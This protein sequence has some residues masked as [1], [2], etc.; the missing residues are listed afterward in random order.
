MNRLAAVLSIGLVLAAPLAAHAQDMGGIDPTDDELQL[1]RFES[2]PSGA[3]I[4][5][6]GEIYG[7]TQDTFQVEKGSLTTIRLVMEGYLPCTYRQGTTGQA[8]MGITGV[9]TMFLCRLEVDPSK[10]GDDIGEGPASWVELD[11]GPNGPG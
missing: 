7:F 8:K 1:Y 11:P 5:Y 6:N 4:E 3:A 10:P 2:I 9:G